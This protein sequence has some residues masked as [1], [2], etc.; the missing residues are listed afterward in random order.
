MSCF[1]YNAAAFS[2]RFHCGRLLTW[3]QHEA[4]PQ[5]GGITFRR[6]STMGREHPH[7]QA[8]LL[9]LWQ[10]R[11]AGRWNWRAS[12]ED[13]QTGS[14]LGFDNVDALC[15]Y[16]RRQRDPP[17]ADGDSAADGE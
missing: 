2:P 1:H 16:L 11:T 3:G 5:N 13:A 6:M 4:R 10:V 15:G 7:Y 17:P 8:Y 9:R 12:L 14:R